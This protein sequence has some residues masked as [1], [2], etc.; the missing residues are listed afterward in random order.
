MIVPAVVEFCQTAG[1][2][3]FDELDPDQADPELSG[4]A[5]NNA[6][7]PCMQLLL[8]PDPIDFLPTTPV[9]APGCRAR[10]VASFSTDATSLPPQPSKALGWRAHVLRAVCIAEFAN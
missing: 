2:A 4:A 8:T 3:Y 7:V 5:A 10:R 9:N 6:H 1:P